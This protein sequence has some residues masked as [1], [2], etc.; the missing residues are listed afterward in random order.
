MTPLVRARQ[1]PSHC[2]ACR[3]GWPSRRSPTS[4]LAREEAGRGEEVRLI[5]MERA[6]LNAG[7]PQ[8]AGG[9]CT[10]VLRDK[11]KNISSMPLFCLADV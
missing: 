9:R 11:S 6:P 1:R 3:S 2:G 4:F 7:A 8:N 10:S 5:K